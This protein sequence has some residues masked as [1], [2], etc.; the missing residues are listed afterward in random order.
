MRLARSLTF[1]VL[2]SCGAFALAKYLTRRDLR[3]LCYH[4]FSVADEHE[5]SPYMF[6]RS[7]TFERRMQLLAKHKIPVISL[8]NAIAKLTSG[9]VLHAETVITFDDGWVTTLT[10]GVPILKKHAFPACVYVTTDHLTGAP[11]VFNVALHYMIHRTSKK[12]LRLSGVHPKIDG[13][14]AIE[15]HR[16]EVVRK[17]ASSAERVLTSPERIELLGKIAPMLDMDLD[18]VLQ[19]RRF[20]LMNAA[21]LAQLSKDGVEIELHTHSHR[22]PENSF[23]SAATEV[24]RNQDILRPI[25]GR[26]PVHFCYPSGKYTKDHPRWLTDLGIQSAT[27]CDSGFNGKDSNPWLLSRYLDSE[28]TTDIEFEA[29]IVGVREVFR[30]IRTWFDPGRRVK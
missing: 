25:I 3:I 17:L 10:I 15:G 12:D 19:N 16:A 28:T 7:E 2:R 6:M 21:E 13:H 26:T 1:Y 29:E 8:Q 24:R 23:E 9:Q 14:F 30:R 4:G 18:V 11:D 27:T 5:I 20:S 22:L